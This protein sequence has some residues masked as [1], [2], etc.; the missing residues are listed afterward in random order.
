MTYRR[1]DGYLLIAFAGMVFGATDWRLF[2][3]LL[4]GDSVGFLARHRNHTLDELREG[5]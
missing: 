1:Y 5:R 3:I 2:A 4:V